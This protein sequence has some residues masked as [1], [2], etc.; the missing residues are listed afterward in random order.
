M[1]HTKPESS[2]TYTSYYS[3]IQEM[4]HIA[5]LTQENAISETEAQLAARNFIG[6]CKT[7]LAI[8][9]RMIQNKE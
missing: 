7:A 5:G 1:P 2:N 6:F 4:H 3:V 9:Q 8:H